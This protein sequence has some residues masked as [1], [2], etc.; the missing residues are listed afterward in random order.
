MLQSANNYDAREIKPAVSL[1]CDNF[2]K[3]ISLQKMAHQ[4]LKTSDTF[5]I[6]VCVFNKNR[7]KTDFSS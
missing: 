6:H 4:N 1:K 7:G 3:T 2:V 5:S